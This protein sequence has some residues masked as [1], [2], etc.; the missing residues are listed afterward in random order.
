MFGMDSLDVLIGLVTVY[1]TLALACTAIV[2]AIASWM[3]LRSKKLEAALTEFLSGKLDDDRQ[4]I[5]AFYEH[6]LIKSLSK[7]AN[8]RPS[9]IPPPIVAQAVLHVLSG[10]SPN[11]TSIEGS[12]NQLAGTPV[13]NRI[14]GLLLAL[15]EQSDGDRVQFQEAIAK[16]FDSVM[17]RASG[18]VKRRQQTVSL[19]VSA[20]LVCAG[21]VDTFAIATSLSSSPD[22]RAKMVATAE[23]RLKAVPPATSEPKDN[24]SQTET[25]TAR[26][27]ATVTQPAATGSGTTNTQS[28]S[29]EAGGGASSN[30]LDDQKQKTEKA[31]EAINQAKLAIEAGGLQFGWKNIPPQNEWVTKALGLF[32]SIFAVAL[33]APFW[34][35]VLQRFMQVRASGASPREQK[36]EKK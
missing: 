33:G 7:G 16:H 9:Y 4:F 14:K 34:F 28:T 36:E 21:N 18:W 2:E 13:N 27:G 24:P 25:D 11:A 32:I 5:Q 35:D 6:P 19:L 20:T 22:L 3:G 31:L 26:E 12:V 30:S 15:A 1:L 29:T 17:D 8:G 10:I 23:Q